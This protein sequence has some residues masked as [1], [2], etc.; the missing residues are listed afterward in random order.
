MT[1]RAL[2]LYGPPLLANEAYANALTAA[3]GTDRVFR[4]ISGNDVVPH[5]GMMDDGQQPTN[6]PEYFYPWDKVDDK[7]EVD[8]RQCP[9][10]DLSSCSGQYPCRDWSWNFHSDIGRFSARTSFCRINQTIP[11]AVY[12]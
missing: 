9:G 3:V 4:I 6:I 10:T 1:V 11:L 12:Q 7:L 5:L 8:V 2:Y